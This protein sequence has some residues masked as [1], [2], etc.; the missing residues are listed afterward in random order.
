[1]LRYG[2]SACCAKSP[3]SR[4]KTPAG[5][6]GSF[7]T[8]PS[9]RGRRAC[10]STTSGARRPPLIARLEAGESIALVSDAGTPIM[11]DPGTHLVASAHAAGIRVEPVPGPSAVIA[12]LSASGLAEGE[13]VFVGFPP[14][15][16]IA[17]KAWF[18][19]L[20]VETRVIVLYEAPH[21]ILATLQVMLETLGDRTIAVAREI[22]KSHEDV[23]VGRLTNFIA[24]APTARGEFTLVISGN[25]P[26]STDQPELTPSAALAEFGQFDSTGGLSRRAA[27]KALALRFRTCRPARSS[28]CS[29]RPRAPASDQPSPEA[30]DL[31]DGGF[32]LLDPFPA[33]CYCRIPGASPSGGEWQSEARRRRRSRS[34]RGRPSRQ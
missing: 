33:V 2:P 17:R 30:Q 7:N 31:D 25:R 32:A 9:R 8:T 10:T 22:T 6:R 34:V 15:R 18:S 20:A 16:A 29:S 23:A 24:C 13:F 28:T 11:S 5:Q 14:S 4:R 21:R 27:L 1:M 26:I 3:S 19:Q 12:A